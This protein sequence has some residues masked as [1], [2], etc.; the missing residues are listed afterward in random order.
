MTL[1]LLQRSKSTS[2]ALQ[3]AALL[4]GTGSYSNP[5]LSYMMIPSTSG[6]RPYAS[7]TPSQLAMGYPPPS[8]SAQAQ[9]QYHNQYLAMQQMTQM[10]SMTQQHHFARPSPPSRNPSLTATGLPYPSIGYS[11]APYMFGSPAGLS[12]GVAMASS[13]HADFNASR[14]HNLQE[15]MKMYQ[16][17]EKKNIQN[18]LQ[19][20]LIQ[21]VLTAPDPSGRLTKLSPRI[22]PNSPQVASSSASGCQSLLV[23]EH[24]V[25]NVDDD[26]KSP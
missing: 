26:S 9:A 3:S 13:P 25:I 24:Q 21:Q 16:Q 19:S 15:Q 14:Q 5:N 6:Q 11:T 1:L 22:S 12:S 18:Q 2:A 4:G 7:S 10:N 17:N 23:S 20:Q 8:Y